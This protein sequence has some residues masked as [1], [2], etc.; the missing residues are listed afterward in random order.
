[1]HSCAPR[2]EKINMLSSAPKGA[3]SQL[4]SLDDLLVKWI[5]SPS[6]ADSIATSSISIINYFLC[7]N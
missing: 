2:R 3:G 7:K 1:M 6:I 4:F 5:P